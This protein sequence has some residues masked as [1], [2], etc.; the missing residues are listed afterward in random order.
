M[1]LVRFKKVWSLFNSLYV[2]VF[3]PL[4][5]VEVMVILLAEF[6][7]EGL[8]LFKEVV[9]SFFQELCQVH[10]VVAGRVGGGLFFVIYLRWVSVH[11]IRVRGGMFP[12]ER[13]CNIGIE[14]IFVERICAWC[15]D[16]ESCVVCGTE[17]LPVGCKGFSFSF[18]LNLDC[19]DFLLRKWVV[20]NVCV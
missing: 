13:V 19:I 17:K 3:V 11:I 15:V 12:G 14:V 1:S 9:W 16:H 18:H 2:P 10:G 5:F 4:R 8:I 6:N 20:L 7:L